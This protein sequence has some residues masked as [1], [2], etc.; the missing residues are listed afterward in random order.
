MTEL[1][2]AAPGGPVVDVT[3]AVPVVAADDAGT[4]AF[5]L[6]TPAESNGQAV[7]TVA[8]PASP[9]RGVSS[10]S[11]APSTPGSPLSSHSVSSTASESSNDVAVHYHS[12]G[13]AAE[14]K[15]EM[16]NGHVDED[17]RKRRTEL[18]SVSRWGEVRKTE[19][20][21]LTKEQQKAQLDRLK[22][23]QERELKWVSMVKSE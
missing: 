7:A 16:S 11:T 1:V 6:D 5:H 21:P 3:V 17:E 22:L 20:K 10:E 18:L 19:N 8:V 12:S 9:H 13:T 14:S 2:V 4:P 15:S 23:D